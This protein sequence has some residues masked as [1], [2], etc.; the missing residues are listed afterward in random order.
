MYRRYPSLTHTSAPTPSYLPNPSFPRLISSLL[1]SKN[2]THSEGKREDISSWVTKLGSNDI[3]LWRQP[4]FLLTRPGIWSVSAGWQFL[5]LP[6][7]QHELTQFM[8]FG[9]THALLGIILLVACFLWVDVV[10]TCQVIEELGTIDYRSATQANV[11]FCPYSDL[12]SM[13]RIDL[14]KGYW[15]LGL[16]LRVTAAKQQ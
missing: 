13:Y 6:P 16:L 9:C 8:Y 14:M 15:S 7:I 5:S 2:D 1:S 3:A 4:W 12:Y 10:H 11:L